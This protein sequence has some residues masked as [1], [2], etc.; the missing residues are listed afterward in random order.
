M[1]AVPRSVEGV[2]KKEI[3]ALDYAVRVKITKGFYSSVTQLKNEIKSRVNSLLSDA[4]NRLPASDNPRYYKEALEG[5]N[6]KFPEFFTTL[7]DVSFTRYFSLLFLGF[8]L[9]VIL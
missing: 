5:L 9:F 1:I 8:K 6:S 3:Y 2:V 4:N 7:F